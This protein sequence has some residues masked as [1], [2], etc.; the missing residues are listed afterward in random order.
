MFQGNVPEKIIQ[1]TTGHRSTEALHSY[2]RVSTEQ[3]KALSKVLMTNTSF[4]N[5]SGQLLLNSRTYKLLLTPVALHTALA[6]CLEI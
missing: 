6:D 1:K 2:E 4:E 5:E 3:E